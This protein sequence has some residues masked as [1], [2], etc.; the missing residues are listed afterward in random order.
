MIER[1][2][3]ATGKK[4]GDREAELEATIEAPQRGLE[5]RTD[6]TQ[7]APR[8]RADSPG[9]EALGDSD[10][11]RKRRQTEAQFLDALYNNS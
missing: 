10:D 5:D 4:D 6:A 9:T 3:M 11:T 1:G 7:A 2:A 8:D